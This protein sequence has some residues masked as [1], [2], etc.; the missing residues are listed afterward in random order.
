MS[1]YTWSRM[2]PNPVAHLTDPAD[3]T[4]QMPLCG[5]R[6][7]IRTQTLGDVPPASSVPVC[8][9]CEARQRADAKRKYDALAT[10][11][12]QALA[13][14]IRGQLPWEAKALAEAKSMTQRNESLA[15]TIADAASMGEQGRNMHGSFIE[16]LMSDLPTLWDR[17]LDVDTLAEHV[18][19]AEDLAKRTLTS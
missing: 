6:L 8:G 17:G 1:K 14:I 15:W 4:W 18:E 12:R 13:T 10:R 11:Y 19:R 16:G 7:D 9:R 5:A 2:T 3:S